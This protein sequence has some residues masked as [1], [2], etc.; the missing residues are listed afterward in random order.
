MGGFAQKL[1]VKPQFRE[2]VTCCCR[3]SIVHAHDFLGKASAA[4]S[5]YL[6]AALVRVHWAMGR[7]SRRHHDPD[8]SCGHPAGESPTFLADRTE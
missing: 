8:G 6:T 4:V 2:A 1:T 7:P 5:F 3:Q